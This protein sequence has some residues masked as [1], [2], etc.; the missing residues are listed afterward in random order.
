MANLIL[1]L[2]LGSLIISAT[3]VIHTFGLIWVTH[4]MNWLT[5]KVRP[6]GHRSRVLAMNTVVIGIFAILTV[7]V[8]LWAAVYDSVG[9]FGDFETSLYFS[10][11]TF[12]TVGYGDV[13]TSHEWRILAAL[14]GVNGFLLI[15]WST[16]Y[17]V[18]AGMRVGPF[19]AGEHF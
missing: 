6:Q 16:A 19:K 8:W 15:G 2:S 11:A 14:E 4:A 10:T 3:V 17:L 12:S 13:I 18:A 7:E 5:N 9:V 1:N